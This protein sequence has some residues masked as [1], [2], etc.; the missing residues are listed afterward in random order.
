MA[1]MKPVQGKQDQYKIIIISLIVASLFMSWCIGYA[2]EARRAAGKISRYEMDGGLQ[3]F[4]LD[5][6]WVLIGGFKWSLA[7]EFDAKEFAARLGLGKTGTVEFKAK[8][9]PWA[10]Y[11][12]IL[13][14]ID[15]SS[16]NMLKE[17]T[18]DKKEVKLILHHSEI[19]RIYEQGG[20]IYKIVPCGE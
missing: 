5:E 3:A 7:D 20:K 19:K 1:M 9:K 12:V 15:V 2:Q 10:T 4:N 6:R 8:R 11:Y 17:T 14:T 18:K 13:Q 16:V